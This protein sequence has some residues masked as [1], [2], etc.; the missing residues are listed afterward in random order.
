VG[1][2]WPTKFI[3]EFDRLP[4]IK[5][6]I[7]EGEVAAKEEI[8]KVTRITVDLWTPD[9]EPFGKREGDLDS[10]F[11]FTLRQGNLSRDRSAGH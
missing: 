8:K 11:F 3:D 4:A 7:R 5:Q 9:F 6:A 1:G 2:Y 10:S